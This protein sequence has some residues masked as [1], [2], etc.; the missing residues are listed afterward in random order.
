M[1][2]HIT[3]VKNGMILMQKAMEDPWK[4]EKEPE[5]P[6]VDI[7]KKGAAINLRIVAEYFKQSIDYQHIDLARTLRREVANMAY[8]VLNEVRELRDDVA[9]F[10]ELADQTENKEMF[11]TIMETGKLSLDGYEAKLAEVNMKI[12]EQTQ[13]IEE[14]LSNLVP[15]DTTNFEGI[16]TKIVDENKKVA[17]SMEINTET[18]IRDMHSQQTNAIKGLIGKREPTRVDTRTASS[19]R[20]PDPGAGTGEGVTTQEAE[21]TDMEVDGNGN[22][23]VTMDE[24]N[25]IPGTSGGNQSNTQGTSTQSTNTRRTK[26]WSDRVKGGERGPVVRT[27]FDHNAETNEYKVIKVVEE[28]KLFDPKL[29]IPDEELTQEEL[30]QRRALEKR[31]K[32]EADRCIMVFGF[33]T[34]KCPDT[35]LGRKYLGL[36]TKEIVPGALGK[37]GITFVPEELNGIQ[38]DWLFDWGNKNPNFKGEKPFIAKFKCKTTRDEYLKGANIAGFLDRR[39]K[40]KVGLYQHHTREELKELPTYGTYVR[41]SKPPKERREEEKVRRARQVYKNTPE[42]GRWKETK[43]IVKQFAETVN[44]TDFDEGIFAPAPDIL[45][46]DGFPILAKPPPR[47]KKPKKVKPKKVNKED[48]N[49]AAASTEGIKD[50]DPDPE[51]IME[52]GGPPGNASIVFASR[53]ESGTTT[54]NGSGNGDSNGNV[55]GTNKEGG[56]PAGAGGLNNN[57]SA[58]N[59]SNEPKSAEEYG[60]ESDLEILRGMGDLE[61]QDVDQNEEQDII[62]VAVEGGDDGGDNGDDDDDD[63]W[64]EDGELNN[65]IKAAEDDNKIKPDLKR[66]RDEEEGEGSEDDDAKIRRRFSPVTNKKQETPVQKADNRVEEKP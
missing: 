44:G 57:P 10:K 12:G 42:F 2:N 5:C 13:K 53:F 50:P 29:I 62:E 61:G 59:G 28:A 33:P 63:E 55:L 39:R 27:A 31:Q 37:N 23:G 64:K 60:K 34:P 16:V 47:E 17:K 56:E 36:L 30:R 7:N 43:K 32:D 25:A 66:L 15:G 24:P 26:T 46:D 11:K 65:T 22:G 49:A 35:K 51:P 3:H 20:G 21:A 1:E 54:G 41:A 14:K 18:T 38:I 48:T 19:T 9:E 4:I 8:V 6:P 40:V 52:G 45:D 58:V